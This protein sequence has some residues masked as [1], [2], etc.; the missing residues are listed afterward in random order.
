MNRSGLKQKLTAVIAIAVVAAV[1]AACSNSS[2]A[3]TPAGGGSAS[4]SGSTAAAAKLSVEL[5]WVPNPDHVGIYYAQN[6]GYFTDANLTVAFH[7]PSNAADPIKL[8]GLNR[9][10]L[11]I[12]YEPEM[13]YGQ[14]NGLPVKAVGTVVPVPLNSLIIAPGVTVTQ[15]SQMAGK[16][17]GVTGIP[18]D[19]AFYQTMLKTAGL[20]ASDV[21]KVNVG[22]SLVPSVLS[23]KVDGIIGGYRNVEAIQMEQETGKKPTVFPADQLGV[24]TYAELVIVA[25]SDRLSSDPAYADAVKRFVASVV[26]GTDGAIADPTG[27]TAV[28][29]QVT[30]YT[31]KFLDQSVPYTLTLLTPA[32]GTKTGC[33]DSAGWQSYGDWMKTNGLIT[34]TPDASAISTNDY[35]PYACP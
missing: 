34:S 13:F 15:L 10:D 19:D 26:K 4:G 23:N 21:T 30:Q 33:I 22:F 18:S 8:V 28:M 9:V 3:V 1:G 11:A 24:P 31:P 2:S 29:K 6:K 20:G 14:Q 17:V 7:P 32:A 27:A 16:T 35:L 25:N 12:S 5:D